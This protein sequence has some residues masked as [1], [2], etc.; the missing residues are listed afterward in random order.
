M[1]DACPVCGSRALSAFIERRAVPVHQNML[2]PQREAARAIPRGDIAL[3][4]CADC[5]FVANAAFRSDLLLY[6]EGYDNTQIASPSFDRYVDGLV[7]RLIEDGVTGKRVVEAGCGKGFFLKRLCLRGNNVGTGFDPSYEG[8]ESEAEG[9]VRYRRVFYGREHAV[10]ADV[11]VCRH[12]IEHVPD[13][14]GFLRDIRGALEASERAVV[15]FEMPAL[16][17]I[18]A[19]GVV[20]DFFYEHCSYFTAASL[21]NT[22]RR[23]G[24]RP[25]EVQ[26]VFGEQYLLIKAVL[27]DEDE[28]L[29]APTAEHGRLLEKYQKDEA[30]QMERWRARVEEIAARGRLAVWGA[31]AKG[32][33]FVNLVDPEAR[34]IQCLFDVN[35]AKQG[36]YAPGTGHPILSPGDTE[37]RSISDAVVMN[38]NYLEEAR[39]MA[40]GLGLM[41]ELHA[42]V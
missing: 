41:L 6:G 14:V 4:A 8:P 27:S 10:E 16:E 2:M 33:T 12:V 40:K 19:G 35:P 42:A 18:L 39:Q 1:K 37:S 20:W 34:R 13:P 7:A 3:R 25:L 15:Y 26:R 24:F 29:E 31:G 17:W 23:A 38:P 21:R 28:P 36:H 30:E 22:F 11:V 9:R 5:G 32:I